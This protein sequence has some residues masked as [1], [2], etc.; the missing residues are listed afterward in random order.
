MRASLP[1]V[2]TST[3][4]SL[5]SCTQ[6]Q[7]KMRC[8]MYTTSLFVTSAW[9]CFGD[10]AFTFR[11]PSAPI[12]VHAGKHEPPCPQQLFQRVQFCQQTLL[13][14][15]VACW[16]QRV[17]NQYHIRTFTSKHL[18]STYQ[19]NFHHDR[20]VIL[21]W[22]DYYVLSFASSQYSASDT[23]GKHKGTC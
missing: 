17:F 14:D 7:L 6:E 16:K 22:D 15:V 5:L 23:Y 20:L 12:C 3:V 10:S 19:S 9:N 2:V 4:A 13:G 1:Y 21:H 8:S 11:T 18:Q